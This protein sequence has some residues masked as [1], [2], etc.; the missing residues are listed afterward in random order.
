M[1]TTYL[2][3]LGSKIAIFRVFTNFFFQNYWIATQV[4]NIIES[5]KILYW[6]SEK[7]GKVGVV[8]RGHNLGQIRLKVVKKQRNWHYQ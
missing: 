7:K 5:P 1:L 3:K 8:F 6:K 2:C 4:I